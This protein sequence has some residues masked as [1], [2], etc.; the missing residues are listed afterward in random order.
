MSA[1]HVPHVPRP[2][3]AV[4]LHGPESGL[5]RLE[6]A[7]TRSDEVFARVRPEALRTR[8]IALRQPFLF[9]VGHLPA[10]AWRHLGQRLRGRPSFAPALDLLFERGIDP[11]DETAVPAEASWPPLDEVRAYRD[12]VRG[13]LRSE[14]G[15]GHDRR[16][17]ER[18][19]LAMV[20]EHERMHQE[21]LLYM[22][23]ETPCERLQRPAGVDY[24][25]ARH[26]PVG[27]QVVLGGGRVRLGVARDELPFAWDNELGPHE[28]AVPGFRM[29]VA[30]VR[31]AEFLRFVEDGGYRDPR[32]W[33][34]AAWRWRERHALDHPRA[35]S[36][37]GGAWSVRTL[38]DVMSLDRVAEW[39]AMVSFAEA[40]AY[41][42]WRGSRLPTEAEYERAA[43]GTVDGSRAY[44]WGDEPPAARHA[45]FD[46]QRWSPDPVGS[47]P[48]G[49]TPEGVLELVGNGW[50]WTRTAFAPYPGFS[51]MPEY[52][53]YSQDFFD[54]EHYVLRGA[55]WATDRELVRRSF[56][57]WFQPH[58]PHVFAKFRC[59][60]PA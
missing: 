19:L 34:A 59:V 6:R 49:A 20:V 53:G 35:W 1:A 48:E 26:A 37:E 52:P 45:N 3:A 32:Q 50:E 40:S 12:R 17:R 24:S 13:A 14:L 23:H 51:A 56:R 21:T 27:A 29:D 47:H 28:V 7:W 30:P 5:A 39:P 57:N 4:G 58:Y 42:R 33:T 10:F 38:F 44:P 2:A 25:S 31:N 15:G 46:L 60:D 18:R 54:G 55:S 36:R 22:V 16:A 9:Y 43:Y 8:P 11:L 41:A